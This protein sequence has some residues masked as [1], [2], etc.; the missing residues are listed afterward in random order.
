MK[1][2]DI[3]VP[4]VYKSSADFRIFLDWFSECLT[5][6]QEDIENITDLIDPERCPKD[7]LW[8]LAET[9]GFRYEEKMLPAYN[10]LVLL[11]FMSMIYNRGSRTGMLLAAETNLAQFNVIDYASEDKAYEDRLADTSVPV[12]SVYLSE[13]PDKGYIDLVYYSEKEPTDVCIEYVR[14]V[15]MYCFT[16][17]GVRVD[18]KTQISVDARLTD[19]NC[20]TLT[21][22]P[23]RVGH[24]RRA[25]YASLQK[26]VTNSGQPY[27]EPRRKVWY[28]NSESEDEAAVNAGYRSLASLQLCNNEHIV[29]SLLPSQ[30]DMDYSVFSV[31]YEPHDVS[32][33]VP[34]DYLKIKDG[35]P[36]NLRYDEQAE[37]ELGVDIYTIDEDRTIDIM[38]PRPAV[39]MPMLQVG[40]AISLVPDNTEYTKIDDQGGITIVH[41]GPEPERFFSSPYVPLNS[42]NYA[43]QYLFYVPDDSGNLIDAVLT[44]IEH[45]TFTPAL[46][47]TF[48][49]EGPTEIKAR[50]Y[51]EYEHEGDTIVV[52]QEFSQTVEV[53]DHG[54]VT[55]STSSYTIYSDGYCYV[56]PNGD[57]VSRSN[58]YWF[59]GS[60]K[61]IS[62]LPWGTTSFSRSRSNLPIALEDVSELGYT[63]MSKVKN[64]SSMFQGLT[65]LKNISNLDLWDVSE[66]T[67]MSQMFSGCQSLVDISPLKT[68]ETPK[69][70][71]FES[72]FAGCYNIETTDGLQGFRFDS[73]YTV[74]NMFEGCYKLTDLSGIKDWD[75]S[76]VFDM[77][78]YR[79]FGKC[80]K[81]TDLTPLKNWNTSKVYNMSCMFLGSDFTGGNPPSILTSL[82]GL[83]NWNVSNVVDFSWMFGDQVWLNDISAIA[84]WNVS[85]GTNFEGM[86]AMTSPLD[87]TPLA[88]WDMS[89]ATNLGSM[90]NTSGKAWWESHDMYVIRINQYLYDYEGNEYYNT[91]LDPITMITQDASA[92]SGWNVPSGSGAFL[93]SSSS[94]WTNIPA[95]N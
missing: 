84:N 45:C 8:L 12:N 66:V 77:T 15:G 91:G 2:K 30:K 46:G 7:L 86:F 6:V 49:A 71:S 73:A 29:K 92:V 90:F 10:R 75:F 18:A 25:D 47:T 72:M 4:D 23:T 88:N 22:G 5:K 19:A 17:A 70:S 68:W 35:R 14:P 78:F 87:L 13:H 63:D 3:P 51:R 69:V 81:L 31:G 59:S 52:E 60:F 20:V 24:Y 54:T 56:H 95:W 82:D 67:N 40:D 9:M 57:Y 79:M 61:K 39:N 36:Y 85:K 1:F 64:M 41:T 21:V 48:A 89:K 76:V 32:V 16:H 38:N 83:E 44:D 55:R 74:A 53:V 33:T 28:R 26:L 42:I 58:G 50:Y 34:D 93:D 27:A 94:T 65:Q 37:A 80:F 11:Y 43:G 62:S